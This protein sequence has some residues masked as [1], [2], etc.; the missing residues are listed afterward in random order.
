MYSVS[1]TAKMLNVNEETVRRWIRDGKLKAK[2][3]V[4]RGGNTL[5]LEDIIAFANQ[6][7]RAYLL[8]LE[9]WLTAVGIAYKK[10]EDSSTKKNNVDSAAVV[11]AGA[12]VAAAA[13]AGVTAADGAGV[14]AGIASAAALAGGP[15]TIGVAGIAGLAYGAAKIM[16]RKNYQKYTIMLVPA[17]E[18][19]KSVAGNLN[20]PNVAEVSASEVLSD[21]PDDQEV[22]QLP[23]SNDDNVR[24]PITLSPSNSMSVLNEIACAKQLLDSGIITTEEFAEIKARLISRI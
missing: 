10:V 23:H 7:P 1:D 19:N 14:G 5:Y 13:G 9:A 4:G 17:E 16:K 22:L 2:R 18:I 24:Q 21:L 8:S 3:G 6:P 12:G 20:D 11:A 15:I